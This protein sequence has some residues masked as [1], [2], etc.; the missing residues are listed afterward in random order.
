MH[1]PRH[2]HGVTD[3]L[4]AF[5]C[6]TATL[7]KGEQRIPR[8]YLRLPVVIEQQMLSAEPARGGLIAS[9][10]AVLLLVF[11]VPRLLS[12]TT[13]IIKVTKDSFSVPMSDA[14]IYVSTYRV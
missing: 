1:D 14:S 13:R 4:S 8:P 12:A 10:A 6:L 5:K 7:C 2:R 11:V 9:L 3:Q